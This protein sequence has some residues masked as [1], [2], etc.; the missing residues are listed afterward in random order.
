ML[1][2]IGVYRLGRRL[3]AS[4]WACLAGA[5]AYA[6][7]GYLVS[8]AASNLP[9]ALGAGSLPLAVDAL[10]GFLDRP[11]PGRMLWAAAALALVAYA[12]EPQSMWLAGLVGGTWAVLRGAAETRLRGALRGA[13]WAAAWGALALCLAAPVALPAAWQLRRSDRA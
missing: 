4:P 9:Y 12:G 13:G 2:G 10:L 1:G 3:S 6:G 8:M 5:A 7:S 11:G